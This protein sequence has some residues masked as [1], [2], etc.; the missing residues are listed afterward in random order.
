MIHMVNRMM[1]KPSRAR[2]ETINSTAVMDEEPA[3]SSSAVGKS[4]GCP[5]S[6]TPAFPRTPGLSVKTRSVRDPSRD[7]AMAVSP[8]LQ[9]RQPEPPPEGMA[10][11]A[12]SLASA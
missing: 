2:P 1:S 10:A 5:P 6:A 11:P 12:P 9:E 7:M 8:P 4:P 3:G